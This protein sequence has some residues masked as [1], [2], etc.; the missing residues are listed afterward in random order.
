[1][2]SLSEFLSKC[3]NP[4]YQYFFL[5]NDS[6]ISGG[7]AVYVTLSVSYIQKCLKVIVN[8]QMCLAP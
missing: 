5:V 1:M 4:R 8:E 2:L 3:F 6:L 7:E